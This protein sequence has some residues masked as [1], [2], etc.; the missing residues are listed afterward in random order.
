MKPGTIVN[1]PGRGVATIV[2]HN[3]DGY[4]VIWGRHNVDPEDLPEPAAMLREP[5][6]GAKYECVGEQYLKEQLQKH[7][8]EKERRNE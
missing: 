1:V 5:Y 4:G 3:L 2:Y 8:R 7:P 6:P